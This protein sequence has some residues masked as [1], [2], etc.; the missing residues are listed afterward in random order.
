MKSVHLGV[1]AAAL[2]ASGAQA[3]QCK[4]YPRMQGGQEVGPL[5][6]PDGA[7]WYANISGNR[8][9]RMDDNFK[10]TPFV[11][12]NGSTGGL[13]GIAFDDSGNVWYS[14][15][16]GRAV[17]KFPM[18]GGEG[19]EYALP[20]ENDYAQD[21]VLGPDGAMWYF[22]PVHQKLGRVAADGSVTVVE[23]PPK[24]N[25]FG[26]RAMARGID[27][28]LWIS[29]LGQNALWKLDVNSLKYKRYDIPE[30]RAHPGDLVVA[31]DGTVWFTMTATKKFG[32]LAPN[33]VFSTVNVGPN[34]V[35]PR[36]VMLDDNGAI[37]LS[38]VGGNLIRIKPDGT[39]DTF[40]CKGMNGGIAMARDGS[41]WGIGN[42]NM[43]VLR[44]TSTNA[45]RVAS[46]GTVATPAAANAGGKIPNISLADLRK[47]F[48][49]KTR[50]VVVHFTVWENKGCGYCDGSFALFEDFA[51]R[52]A[53]KATFVRVAGDYDD[54]MWKD[55]LLAEIG[56]LKGFPTFITYYDQ[57]EVARVNGRMSVAVMNARLLP[58]L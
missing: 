34:G 54:P 14:K 40:S 9:V 38:D 4:S 5:R 53:G 7:M 31:K 28:S 23:P 8:I 16:H 41:I 1:L 21:L 22:D 56:P 13:S 37:W 10:E 15:A 25:P 6:A 18:A 35:A 55:P 51:S 43:Q 58:A 29:D 44:M 46:T 48:A 45:P 24:L 36:T 11:P 12:V 47:L 33:G 52:N 19:V 42:G 57:Q 50:K 26:P 39:T 32:R 49:D 3:Q 30:P 17:G 27:N 2:L 20:P